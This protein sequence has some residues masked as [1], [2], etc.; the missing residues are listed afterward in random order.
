MKFVTNLMKC[1][2]FQDA[3][4]VSDALDNSIQSIPKIFSEYKDGAVKLLNDYMDV[5][6]VNYDG[7]SQTNLLECEI[8]TGNVKP[9]RMRPYSTAHS[10]REFVRDEIQK[11]VNEGILF[12]LHLVGHFR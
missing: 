12:P 3:K 2:G 4:E 6:S 7:M 5:F 1:L 10:E 8:D 11:M 9:I